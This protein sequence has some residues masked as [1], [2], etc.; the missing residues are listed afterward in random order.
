MMDSA[1]QNLDLVFQSTYVAT[2][3]VPNQKPESFVAGWHAGLSKI[4]TSFESDLRGTFAEI[5]KRPSA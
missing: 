1:S 4:L 5:G 3:A 2:M